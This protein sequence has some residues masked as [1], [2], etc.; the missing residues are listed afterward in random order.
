MGHYCRICGRTRPNEKFSGKGHRDHVCKDCTRLP[1]E[2][3]DAIEQK[4]EIFNYLKQSHISAKNTA[5]LRRLAA[6]SNREI[7]ELATI[8]I[9]VAKVKPYKRRRLKV[10]ARQRRDLLDALE[11]TGLIAAHHG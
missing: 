4:E 6:S 2:N 3:R 5:R 10:L 1:K 7:A 11:R 9:E 8:V